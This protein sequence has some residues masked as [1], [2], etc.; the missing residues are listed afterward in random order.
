MTLASLPIH[1]V[2]VVHPTAALDEVIRLLD[3][4]P[5]RTVALVGDGTY[6]GIFNDAAREP[7]LIPTNADLSS[8][9]VGPYVHSQRAIGHPG[10]TVPDA[11]ALALR[12]RVDVLPMVDGPRFLG[13]ITL[14]ELEA[15]LP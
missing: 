7:G 8:L 14:A 4:T 1:T 6:L 9:Q 10:M 15:A 2:P 5:L 11:L 13:V 12:K 3:D